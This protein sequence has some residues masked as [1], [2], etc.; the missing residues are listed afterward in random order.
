MLCQNCGKNEATTHIKRIVN[1]DKEEM[2]LCS[3]CAENMGYGD[4]FTDFGFF[5]VGNMFANFLADF[6]IAI[7]TSSKTV[8]CEKCGNSFEDIVRS[9]M[10]G[11]ADCY[12][13][14][15]D[16]LLPSLQRIHGKANHVGKVGALMGET[17]KQISK[18]DMLKKELEK[19]VKEQNYEQSAILRDK[20]KELES[21][22]Q[23]NE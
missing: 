1:G 11:C 15:Y 3:S 6:P 4:L 18:I 13:T 17:D 22:E 20:I 21:E 19:T 16:R 9:G 23:N 7:G 8:R 2:N 10:I 5:N 12:S 14:F